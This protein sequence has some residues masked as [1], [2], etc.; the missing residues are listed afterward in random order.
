L[1]NPACSGI[2]QP[3]FTPNAKLFEPVKTPM[4]PKDYFKGKVAYVT[5]GGTGLGKSMA[6]TLSKLGANV[7][8]TSRRENVLKQTAEEIK[9]LT[10]NE[11]AYFPS[12][13]RH[14]DQIEKSLESCVSSLGVPTLVINNAAG[15]FI[16]PSERISPNGIKTIVDIVL[17]GTLN[18]TLIIGKRLIKEQKPATFLSILTT[19]AQVGSGFVLPSA[20]AKAGI[21]SMTRGLAVEW[22][23]YGIRLNGISPGPIYT[24]GA[25][26]RLDPTGEFT[27]AATSRIP[28]GRLGQPEELANLASYLLS[29]YSNWMTGQVIDM[30]GG[31]LVNMS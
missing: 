17:L 18:T 29:D 12:D 28:I 26:T 11:V 3:D 19:Y 4:L 2:K 20:C 13:V 25:F 31:E 6:T 8:I 23:R 14:A 9:A 15:N 7:F 10:G 30:D 16:A 21:A 1:I 22:S 27:K 24:E 5:G